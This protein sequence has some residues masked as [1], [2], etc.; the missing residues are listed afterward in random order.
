MCDRND[1]SIK[2][3]SNGDNCPQTVGSCFK[4]VVIIG[5]LR[6]DTVVR[7]LKEMRINTN[8]LHNTASRYVNTRQNYCNRPIPMSAK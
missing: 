4:I 6:S 1:H 5:V 2:V 7:N 8:I 3:T